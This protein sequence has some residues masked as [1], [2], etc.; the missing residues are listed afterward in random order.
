LTALKAF[1]VWLAGKP[2]YKS[3]ISYADTED[4]NMTMKDARIAKAVREP[5]VPRANPACPPL[6]TGDHGH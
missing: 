5:R 1:F 6:D 3:R 4:F 2:G